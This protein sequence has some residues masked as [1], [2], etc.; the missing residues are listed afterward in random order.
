MKLPIIAGDIMMSI[1]VNLEKMLEKM[2]PGPIYSQA[3][4][5]PWGKSNVLFNYIA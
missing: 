2:G 5:I 1:F 4:F 3:P